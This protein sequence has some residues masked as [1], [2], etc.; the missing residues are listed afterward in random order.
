MGE[1]VEAC[2]NFSRRAESI[3]EGNLGV[4]G[5]IETIIA[6]NLD[7]IRGHL[8]LVLSALF[9][10]VVDRT[11]AEDVLSLC[12]PVRVVSGFGDAIRAQLIVGPHVRPGLHL[13]LLG[14]T[15][16]LTNGRARIKFH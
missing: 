3:L 1:L 10:R 7:R 5:S 9:V 13:G 12:K 6:S 8:G 11:R 4:Y 16:A 2:I 14:A 15:G